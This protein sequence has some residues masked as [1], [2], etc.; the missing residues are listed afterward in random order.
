MLERAQ[1][2]KLRQAKPEKSDLEAKQNACS[3]YL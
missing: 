1:Q 3:F 2:V